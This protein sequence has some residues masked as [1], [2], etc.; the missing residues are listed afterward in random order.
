MAAPLRRSAI[1]PKLIGRDAYLD[2]IAHVLGQTRQ[3]HGHTL[4][5]AGEAGIGKSRLVAEIKASIHQDTI[6]VLQGNCFEPDRTLPYGPLID[7]LRALL[8]VVSPASLTRDIGPYAAEMVRLLPELAAYLRDAAAGP[9]LAPEQ[10]KRR[11]FE[12]LTRLLTQ[13]SARQPIMLVAE[14][15]H[16]A[17]NTSLEYLAYL[18]RR[19]PRLPILLLLTYRSDEQH[20]PLRHFLAQL[21]RERLATEIALTPLAPS[22]VE[23]MLDT[24]FQ[25]RRPV[26]REFLD[27][28]CDLTE[29]NPFFIEEVL[30]ALLAD[31]EIFYRDGGWE[32][33]PLHDLHIPRSVQDAVRRRAEHLSPAAQRVMAFASVVGLRFDFALLQ[34]VMGYDEA[35]LLALLKELIAAQLV[36]EQSAEHFAFRHALTRK[37]IYAELLERERRMIHREIV[38]AIETLYADELE[39]HVSELAYHTCQAGDWERV[40]EY[41]RRAGEH[42]LALYAPHAALEEFLRALEAAAHL[43]VP[44]APG[45]YRSRANAYE[46][47]GDFEG[48]R[49]DLETALRLA[50]ETEDAETEWET[51][52]DLGLLWAGRDY[53]RSGAYLQQALTLVNA[54]ESPLKRA[55]TLNRLG[56]WHLNVDEPLTA[57]TC[58]REAL[59]IFEAA[60]DKQGVART[61]D[62]L[63]MTSVLSNDLSAGV[64]YGKRAAE[65]LRALDDRQTLSSTLETLPFAAALRQSQTMTLTQTTLGEATHQSE[66]GLRIAREMGWRVGEASALWVL[67]LCSCAS[68]EFG[69]AHNS[70]IAALAIAEE[71]EHR[72]W[73]TASRY[74]LGELAYELYAL[75]LAHEHL[76]RGLEMARTTGSWHWIRILSALLAETCM[77]QGDLATAEAVLNA[78]VPPGTATETVGQRLAWVARGE[79][80]LAQGSPVIALDIA[81]RLGGEGSSD[82]PPLVA[83][84]G[85]RALA[86]SGRFD[87]AETWLC[88]AEVTLRA[89]GA[90][91]SLRRVLME[92]ATLY[93][94][95]GRAEDAARYASETHSLIHRLAE[96]IPDAVLRAVFMR[97]ALAS[98]PSRTAD[99]VK[100]L[101][102]ASDILTAREREVAALVAQGKSNRA[103][104][105]ELVVSERTTE[106]HIT[107][108]LG[109]LGFTSRA[110]IAAWAV[111]IGLAQLQTIVLAPRS[112]RVS[113]RRARP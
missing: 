73:T 86:A 14:D 42:A 31:N 110:Q 61:L 58:H 25:L 39:S 85:G 32:R 29:G 13:I 60:D 99:G 12:A 106:S 46:T 2:S 26:R 113:T 56:N 101:R 76:E 105:D 44:V 107:N 27:A 87:E 67:G 41:A 11:L 40:L 68:G 55:R 37:A 95:M 82:D 59:A 22:E 7:A 84:L 35:T 93:H 50:Y 24:I 21:D 103:I 78:G 75:A 92:I 30:H 70:A 19:I 74:T 89:Q 81:Q 18:A 51:L 48:A 97:Q 34:H 28:M 96:T 62:L 9:T 64:T 108:I 43:G 45:I 98:L 69:R 63:C 54:F 83:L 38:A 8:T 109:K 36:V 23:E 100:M 57:K 72:Q 112:H 4:L 1:C 5:L 3:A 20:P 88:T 49:R 53:T 10:E 91:T 16:W 71:I 17:D 77:A 104:A 80:A 79:L 33:K 90:R 47:L 15:I 94:L 52:L 6:L 111:D 102:A 66:E 65:M